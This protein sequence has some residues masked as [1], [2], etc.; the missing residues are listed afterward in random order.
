MGRVGVGRVGTRRVARPGTWWLCARP[1]SLEPG[2][3]GR[4]GVGR[5]E[6][7]RVA[8]LCTWWRCAS[9]DSHEGRRIGS[10]GAGRAGSG[11]VGARRAGG[12]G[13]A[14]AAGDRGAAGHAR[15]RVAARAGEVDGGEAGLRCGV[16]DGLHDAEVEQLD[17]VDLVGGAADEQVRRL[18]VAVEQPRVVGLGERRAGLDQQLDHAG[19]G[20]RAVARDQRLEVESVEQLHHVVEHAEL[21]DAVVVDRD[22][23]ARPHRRQGLGLAAEPLVDLVDGARVVHR[24]GPDQL[25]RGGAREQAVLGAPHLAHA[26]GAEPRDQPVAAELAGAG[27][28]GPGLGAR[29]RDLAP[30]P[31]QIPGQHQGE[32]DGDRER[33]GA[34]DR[35]RSLEGVGR[36]EQRPG[37]HQ[38]RDVPVERDRDP[39][40][41]AADRR[42]GG[43]VAAVAG[44][45][46]GQPQRAGRLGREQRLE[47][48][49]AEVVVPQ[50]LVARGQREPIGGRIGE[51][52]AV[53]GVD[54]R[55]RLIERRPRDVLRQRADVEIDGEHGAQRAVGGVDR[56]GAGDPGLVA[57]EERVG[58]RPGPRARGLGEPVEPAAPR[59]VVGGLAAQRHQRAGLDGI[60]P[61][62][63]AVRRELALLDR[64]ARG[65]DALGG[66]GLRSTGRLVDPTGG[67]TP[68]PAGRAVGVRSH[69]DWRRLALLVEIRAAER[70]VGEADTDVGHAGP[71]DHEVVEADQRVV[72]RARRVGERAQ[73]LEH[74][75]GLVERERDVGLHAGGVAG[76]QAAGHLVGRRARRVAADQQDADADR[77]HQRRDRDQDADRRREQAREARGGCAIGRAVGGLGHRPEPARVRRPQRRAR[78]RTPVGNTTGGMRRRRGGNA[79]RSPRMSSIAK[80]R[81]PT[82]P[83]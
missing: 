63:G 81:P 66:A 3:V 22:G 13:G 14:R 41:A 39:G 20:L 59:I 2:P 60:A 62:V 52:D 58:L 54:Q 23:V 51:D 19:G 78:V 29:A 16:V 70:A 46:L 11:I 74:G 49:I 37:R 24:L 50:Q 36:P 82:R 31:H 83:S 65:G 9:L 43:E 56:L 48:G 72:D 79:A 80:V 75:T 76:E 28:G 61:D 38:R 32:P 8:R 77:D 69:P 18:D 68:R 7:C 34:G 5:V 53:A 10:V 71:S 12:A 25:D 4:V 64:D 73:L 6:T 26:A 67:S 33:A 45:Q 15:V 44:R 1:D 47:G 57:G 40:A 27:L 35:A 21:G 17:D 42:D 55:A 30:H